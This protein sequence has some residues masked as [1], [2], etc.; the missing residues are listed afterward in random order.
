[1]HNE[2]LTPTR[3]HLKSTGFYRGSALRL[4]PKSENK[5]F[6]RPSHAT[7]A[8]QAL[9]PS[10]PDM[11]LSWSKR[12]H[13]HQ[14]H[15]NYPPLP[16][17]SSSP[18]TPPPAIPTPPRP[19]SPTHASNPPAQPPS[20]AFAANAPYSAPQPPEQHPYPAFRPP[21]PPPP[22]LPPYNYSFNF[23]NYY[24][25]PVNNMGQYPNYRPYYIPQISGWGPSVAPL[26]PPPPPLQPAPYVDHQSAKKIKNDV[27]VHKDTI[28]IQVDEQSQ[29]VTWFL[30]PLMLW[31]MAG[32][33]NFA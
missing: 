24:S 8:R 6:Q 1:M 21:P 12:H 4:C 14:N 30:S 32:L 31:L 2:M 3:S 20:Y 23:S 15:H 28:R 18:V 16:P 26:P 11:G 10:S 5:N 17:S 19:T 7:T 25:R 22:P 9:P 13:H 33:S 29:T 27:N